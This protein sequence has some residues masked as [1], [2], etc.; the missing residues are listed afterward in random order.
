MDIELKLIK[1]YGKRW[2]GSGFGSNDPGR[3]REETNKP[4]AGFDAQFPV[5][6]DIPASVLPTGVQTVHAALMRLKE[7]LPYD[8]RYEVAPGKAKSSHDYRLHPH[9]DYV[10]HSIDVP[11]APLTTREA[12]EIIVGALPNGW[13]ATVFSSHV[14]LYKEARTYVYGTTI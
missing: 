7:A 5:D 4:E 2:N 3:N 8:L 11:D 10:A 1:H 13:Q 14:I 12:M 6:I 9:P